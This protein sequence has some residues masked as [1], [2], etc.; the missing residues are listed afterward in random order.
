MSNRSIDAVLFDFAGVMTT[1][2]FEASG[3]IGA[4]AGVA[5][6]LVL[7]L[8][9]GPYHEDTDHP[10]HRLERGEIPLSEYGLAVAA[11]AR[12]AGLDL[13]FAS[14]RTLFGDLAIRDDVVGRVTELR[15]DGYATALITNNVREAA[16]QWRRMLALDDLFDVVV[17]SSAVGMRK[18][19]P[20]IYLHALAL[21]DGVAPDRAVF[22]DDA[23]GKVEGARRAGLHAIHVEDPVVALAELD[24]LLGG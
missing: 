5:P 17:D 3:A 4:A 10:W 15:A 21:L 23:P 22:L 2:P 8:M 19:D 6:E 24:V 14:L 1:S 20:R 18:P 13:D 12:A 9:L 7:E 11:E 16:G